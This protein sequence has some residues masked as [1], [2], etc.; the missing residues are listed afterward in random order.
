M[1]LLVVIGIVFVLLD[2]I[3]SEGSIY[4][5]LQEY[6]KTL[7]YPAIILIIL[8]IFTAVYVFVQLI[9]NAASEIKLPFTEVSSPEDSADDN[10]DFELNIPELA[11]TEKDKLRENLKEGLI[12]E[13]KKG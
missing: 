10:Q 5:S 8:G 1:R 12:N 7:A 9:L 2:L 11:S 13:V 3:F 6:P 4:A